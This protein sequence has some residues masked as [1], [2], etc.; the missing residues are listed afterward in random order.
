MHITLINI[1]IFVGICH[2][3]LTPLGFHISI[4]IIQTFSIDIPTVK[5]DLN[6]LS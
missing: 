1:N 2:T 5:S 4:N 3:Y 6:N